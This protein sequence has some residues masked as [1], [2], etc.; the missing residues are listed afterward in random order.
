MRVLFYILL[1][2]GIGNVVLRPEMENPLTLYRI[3]APVCLIV[4]FALR[5]MKVIRWL[6]LFAIF[7]VYNIVLATAYSL[8][9]SQFFPSIVH[10]LYLFILLVLMVDM[11]SQNVDFDAQYLRFVE[12][13]YVFLLLNL[14]VEF[15]VGTT[16]YPNLYIDETDEASL[17]A[18]FWNQNDVAIVL[19]IVAW[20]ALTLDRYKGMVRW[21]VVL[22]TI[23]V[24]YYNDS[25][26]ALLSL[27]LV[28]LPIYSIFRVCRTVSI[29]PKVWFAFFG[30]LFAL[31][32]VSIV[33]LS[34]VPINFLNDTYTL[35]DLL[36]DPITRIFSLQASDEQWG[37]LNN[38]T[39]AAIFV[40][41][42]YLKSFGFGLGAGGS[43]LVLTMPQYELGG[44]KSAHN[45]LLQFIVDFGYP[46][47]FG[48]LA[49]VFWALSKLFKR[50]IRE[51][52]RLK[53]MAILSFPLLGLSQSG[54]IVTNYFFFASVYF[55]W[56]LGH[57]LGQTKQSRETCEIGQINSQSVL[58]DGG[59]R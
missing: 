1:I 14:L 9:Y 25:K 42:E 31:V 35:G 17:R 23:L 20:L 32:V 29:T 58:H 38:R 6:G 52:D 13:F 22:I 5:P 34:G 43:W 51:I 47:L 40:I 56:M 41:I 11:K 45:A 37:S 55:I 26:A 33:S 8:D 15:F 53:V 21:T 16:I 59:A 57:E 44:A 18:F 10:Y 28:S 7:L 24:L 36:V 30:T 54:A 39:D 2:A 49:M 48:Y 46:V 3:L 12:W 50:S 4:L 27:M 19:C